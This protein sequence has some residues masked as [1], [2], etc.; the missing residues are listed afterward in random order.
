MEQL[1][2]MM[3]DL[4]NKMSGQ[5]QDWHKVLDKILM[6]MDSKVSWRRAFCLAHRRATGQADRGRD[7]AQFIARW[8]EELGLL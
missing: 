4:V 8:D 7:L 2:K 6:E 1:N 5:E 3:Q